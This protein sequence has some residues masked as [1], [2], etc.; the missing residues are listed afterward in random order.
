M[1]YKI[2]DIFPIVNKA[3][4]GDFLK[5][6]LL[7]LSIFLPCKNKFQILLMFTFHIVIIHTVI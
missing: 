6:V 3:G 4:F 5:F 1:D 2:G 7:S